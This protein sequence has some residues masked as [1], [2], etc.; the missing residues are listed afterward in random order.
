MKAIEE[1]QKE[2]A[3]ELYKSIY[4]LMR[5]ED[6]I[7]FEEFYAKGIEKQHEISTKT[8]AEILAETRELYYS[9]RWE[10]S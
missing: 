6:F 5:E 4:P 10:V 1:K 8:A 9:H 3:F 7:S 2:Q